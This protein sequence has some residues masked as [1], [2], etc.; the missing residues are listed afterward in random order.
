MQTPNEELSQ[1]V[2]VA[3]GSTA[4]LEGEVVSEPNSDP[5]SLKISRAGLPWANG[6]RRA[7]FR[8]PEVSREI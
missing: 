5:P 6:G 2:A 7:Y 1:G 4:G 8:T 3:E